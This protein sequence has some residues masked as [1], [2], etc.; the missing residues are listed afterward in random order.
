MALVSANVEVITGRD[1]EHIG[2]L[3][4]SCHGW[5]EPTVW[6]LPVP[7]EK[8]CTC[9]HATPPEETRDCLGLAVHGRSDDR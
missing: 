4:I 9:D 1:G 7:T 3:C 2:T 6:G 8:R 5:L